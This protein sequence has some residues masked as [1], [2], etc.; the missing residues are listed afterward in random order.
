MGSPFP[1]IEEEATGPSSPLFGGRK[2]DNGICPLGRRTQDMTSHSMEPRQRVLYGGRVCPTRMH[3]VH[4][5]GAASQ[6]VS[7]EFSQDHLGALGLGVGEN[8]IVVAILPVRILEIQSASVHSTRRNPDHPPIGGL[9]QTLAQQTRQ[10]EWPDHM[11]GQCEFQAI[12]GLDA[13][14]RQNT[15]IVHQY[16]DR[17]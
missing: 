6:L 5:D 11:S 3:R 10:Q 14:I 8:T 17:S 4:D 1:S 9:F 13:L 16:I 12:R 2:P 15:C 7:P